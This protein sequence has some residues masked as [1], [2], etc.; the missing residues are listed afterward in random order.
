M[1]ST[2]VAGGPDDFLC[3]RHLELRGSQ[4]DIGRTLAREVLG[5][6]L[7]A[8]APADRI[9][10]R[11]RRRWFEREWPEHYAR[12]GGIADAFGVALADDG[13]CVA[14]L[15]ATPLE[16]GCSALWCPP[17]ASVDGHAR[18]G[19]DFDFMTGSVLEVA[20][21]PPDPA[22]PPMM[23]RPYV[24]ETHP[25]DGHT[26]IV[27]VGGDLSGCFEG[28]NDAG[29]AITLFADDEST[30]LRPAHQPQAG[31]HELQLPRLLLDRCTT[32]EE[33]LEVLYGTKQYDNFVTCHYLVADAHGDA[34]V[35]ST[36][37]HNVEHVVRARRRADVR[38]Q[39]PGAPLRERRRVARG[40]APDSNMYERA[41]VLQQRLECVPLAPADI[42][43]AMHTVR[44]EGPEP[45]ART[46]WT[47]LYDLTERSVT[48]EFYL[49]ESAAGPQ[50]R[51]G[52]LTYALSA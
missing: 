6:F 41:R 31:V 38:H 15:S 33:A 12:M 39:L 42:H 34:L 36:D 20:G 29:L 28:I 11:A 43:A 18:I 22:Q 30:T 48:L 40:Q 45:V 3:V 16:I 8:P 35:W 21:L 5:S 13:A 44:V 47:A 1:E 49:G 14:E 37:S 17:S 24:I 19:R 32:V 26:A 51:S 4:F 27:V 7:Q 23:S 52:D 10:N 46:M 25:D 2:L 50:R 9:L